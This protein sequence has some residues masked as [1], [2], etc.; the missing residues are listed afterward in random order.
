LIE[1]STSNPPDAV[2]I[3][4]AADVMKRNKQL[5]LVVRETTTSF[6]T[7]CIIEN[8]RHDTLRASLIFL[9]LELRPISGPCAVIGVDPSP[10]FSS[11][12]N[13]EELRRHKITVE[14]GRVKNVTKNPVAEKCIA[15]LDDELLRVSPE[16]GAVSPVTLAIATANLNTRIRRKRT[17]CP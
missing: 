1:Q 4:F 17:I 3:S 12:S 14:I 2:G 15:E 7:S 8:E 16:G 9:C 13:D 6:T 5:I 11:L 10:A